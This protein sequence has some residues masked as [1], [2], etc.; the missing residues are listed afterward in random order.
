VVVVV[1]GVAEGGGG[2]MVEGWRE[3]A[4]LMVVV[5]GE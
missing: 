2:R 1:R 3:A 5:R 4:L